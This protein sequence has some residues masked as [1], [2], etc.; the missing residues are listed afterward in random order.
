MKAC[1][2]LNIA[3]PGNGRAPPS[4]LTLFFRPAGFTIILQNRIKAIVNRGPHR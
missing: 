4:A 1:G 3:A 2:R